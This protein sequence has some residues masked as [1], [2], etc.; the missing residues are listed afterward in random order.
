M[1]VISA[2]DLDNY[3]FEHCYPIGS[4]YITES[5][6][7][8]N[9][10]LVGGSNSTWEKIQGKFIKGTDDS[11]TAGS[12]GGSNNRTLSI[13]NLPSHN[14]SGSTNS[15]GA[16]THKIPYRTNTNIG[17]GSSGQWTTDPGTVEEYG[18]SV[19]SAGNH[20]HTVTIGNTGSGT[21]FDNQPAYIALNIWKRVG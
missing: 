5:D 3:I 12:T 4:I 2:S 13:A 16:H 19:E 9:V 7:N 17:T 8:P 1:A 11:V 20:S 10:L 21:A 14:H 18:G 15:T 6:S